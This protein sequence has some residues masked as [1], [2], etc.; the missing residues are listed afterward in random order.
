[1]HVLWGMLMAAIGLFMLVCGTLK[2]ELIIYRLMASGQ[3]IPP[4]LKRRSCLELRYLR[5]TDLSQRWLAAFFASS[6]QPDSGFVVTPVAAAE[7]IDSRVQRAHG[8]EDC[9]NPQR[10]TACPCPL[11]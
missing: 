8:E 3:N 5:V 10:L 11:F 4:N 9:D 7:L 6:K 2:S 1:M